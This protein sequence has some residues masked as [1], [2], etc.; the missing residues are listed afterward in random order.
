MALRD[1]FLIVFVFG[2]L[3]WMLAKPYVGILFWCWLGYMNPHRLSWGVAYNLPFSQVVA[4]TTMVGLIFS[5][6]PKRIPLT[7]LTITWLLFIIWMNITTVYAM[8][9]DIAYEQYIKVMKIQ[10]MTFLT[11]VLMG[12]KEKLHMLLWVIV[13]S[14][15]FYGVK[16]GIFT[17]IHGGE[18]RVWGPPGSFVE[19][20]NGLAISLIMML[21]LVK[22]LRSITENRW[23]R[24]GLLIAMFLMSVSV[25]GSYSRAALISGLSMA[26]FLWVKSK[27][28]KVI[29]LMAI[30]ILIPFLYLF[31]PQTWHDRMTSIYTTNEEGQYEGSAQSRIFAWKMI[32]NLANHRPLGAGFSP[33]EPMT[34]RLYSD[35]VRSNSGMA[36]HSI[37][38]SPLAEHG[39]IGLILFV[40]ILLMAWRTGSWVICHCR[41]DPELEWLD[42]LTRMVQLALIAYCTGGTFHQMTY[43][44]LPWDMIAIIVLSKALLQKRIKETGQAKGLVPQWVT[45]FQAAKGIPSP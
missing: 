20:N 28:N 37:Y 41:G 11:I 19:D 23:V 6:E 3:P 12:S 43:Y 15:G 18:F 38:M 16:G 39:W 26:S 1:L 34:Y 22:Y 5:K 25:V 14:L 36:A 32:L 2:S 45:P 44:D 10:L 33:W 31:M 17:I 30:A 35:D 40:S 13:L 27:S 29:T 7:G 8:Y 9:P 24:Q 4:L 21:P 42:N